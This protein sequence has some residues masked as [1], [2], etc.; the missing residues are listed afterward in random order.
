MILQSRSRQPVQVSQG[1]GQIIANAHLIAACLRESDLG[2]QHLEQPAHAH[3][4]ALLRE[5]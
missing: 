5:S 4:V 2:V 1:D 3:V